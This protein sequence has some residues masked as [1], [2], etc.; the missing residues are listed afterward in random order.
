MRIIHTGDFHFGNSSFSTKR[1]IN[2][3]EKYFIPILKPGDIVFMAGDIFDTS[4]SLNNIDSHYALSFFLKFFQLAEKYDILVRVIRGTFSHDR[5][6]LEILSTLY[7]DYQFTFDFSYINKIEFE[8]IKKHKIKVLYIPDDL[9]FK[10]STEIIQF[11]KQRLSALGWKN[12]DYILGHGNFRHAFPFKLNVYPKITFDI[13]QFKDIV[14]KYILFGHIHIPSVKANMIYCGSFDRLRHGERGK[15][16]FFTIED[17]TNIT[18]IEN[19]S[20]MIFKDFVWKK[21]YQDDIKYL[22]DFILKTYKDRVG[23]IRLFNVSVDIKQSIVSFFSSKFPNIKY[24][25]FKGKIKN[26]EIKNQLVKINSNLL[27]PTK[28]NISD[29]IYDFIKKRYD[30]TLDIDTIKNHFNDI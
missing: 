30:K 4:I 18:F 17:H 12:V 27:T 11:I 6:Q 22:E 26:I 1:I 15:K 25:F 21:S 5:N 20:A 13:S 23:F 28:E 8:Y 9:S 7:K 24:S 16:G 3:L 29:I 19:L 2:N 10:S 14:T